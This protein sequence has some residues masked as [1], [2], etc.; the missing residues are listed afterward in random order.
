[1]EMRKENKEEETIIRVVQ[2]TDTIIIKTYMANK[3]HVEEYEKD[4]GKMDKFVEG[5]IKRK[6]VQYIHKIYLGNA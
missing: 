6:L 1:M 3:E 4:Y 5:L 2:L